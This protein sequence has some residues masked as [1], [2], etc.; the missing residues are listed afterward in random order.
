[1]TDLQ[2]QILTLAD[3]LTE[4]QVHQE[5][6][7]V[8]S[9]SRH[10]LVRYHRTVQHGLLVQLHHAVLPSMAGLDEGAG[11]I[12]AS[13]PP[14][15]VEALSRYEE[16]AAAACAWC[17]DL[18]LKPRVLPEGNI[19]LLVGAPLD[20]I[21]QKALLADLRR[22]TSWCRVYL[23][24]EQVRQIPGVRCLVDDCNTLGSLRINLTTSH[25]VCVACGASWDEKNIGVLAEHIK[26]ARMNA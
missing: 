26:A 11:S 19:R 14:L 15:E 20:K 3:V 21:Q 16:I 9:T 6:Y 18:E 8:W 12:P 13:R 23:G 4:T 24:L 22:W 17:V 2:G 7:E 25:G 10:R 5:R 1:M